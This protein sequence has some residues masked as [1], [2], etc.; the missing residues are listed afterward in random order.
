MWDATKSILAGPGVRLDNSNV[1]PL[2]CVDRVLALAKENGIPAQYGVTGG[3]NDGAVFLRCGSVD[4]A[5]GW[6]QRY[7]HSPGEVIDTKGLDALSKIVEM[8]VGGSTA[9]SNL[10]VRHAKSIWGA[11]SILYFPG[12]S[13]NR[14]NRFG[15]TD[16]A[17]SS[18]QRESRNQCRSSYNAIRWIFGIDLWK[19][20]CPRAH[21][22]THR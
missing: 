20:R 7:S 4:V 18:Q 12:F 11:I 2:R 3:A 1:A 14:L 9:L 13:P 21:L 8:L 19:S 6:P 16:L 5:L 17:V 10:N 15:P 22:A